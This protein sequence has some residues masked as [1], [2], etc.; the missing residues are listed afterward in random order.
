MQS[1][2]NFCISTNNTSATY[3]KD[4]TP[5]KRLNFNTSKDIKKD[6]DKQ[7]DNINS[8]TLKSLNMA[9]EPNPVKKKMKVNITDRN[10]S[11]IKH[12]LFA[13]TYNSNSPESN[14]PDLHSYFSNEETSSSD[15]L[16]SPMSD[17]N[18]NSAYI[19][20]QENINNSNFNYQS[21]IKINYPANSFNSYG[22]NNLN[23]LS[24]ILFQKNQIV[25]TTTP[26]K[27]TTKTAVPSAP[28]RE[29]EEPLL[30][31]TVPVIAFAY[32]TIDSMPIYS[33]NFEGHQY[34]MKNIGEEIGKERD[35]EKA[36]FHHVYEFLNMQDEDAITINNQELPL[37]GLV[38][39]VAKK[40]V[41]F[42]DRTEYTI[43]QITKRAVQSFD[44]LTEVQKQYPGFSLPTCH[45]KPDYYK[46]CHP[47]TANEVQYGNLWIMQKIPGKIDFSKWMHLAGNESEADMIIDSLDEESKAC[48]KFAKEIYQKMKE[49]DKIVIDDCKPDNVGF[50]TVG[51][52]K[53]KTYQFYILDFSDSNKD[54]PRKYVLDLYLSEWSRG[55]ALV[56]YWLTH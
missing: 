55:N 24:S 27:K 26:V 40:G 50:T 8:L 49:D 31:S 56:K 52:D 7:N 11:P 53:D 41:S 45:V 1:P 47:E 19:K 12:D 16:S 54:E 15:G 48:L 28:I 33:M 30:P 9:N 46:A 10:S 37:S 6:L 4:P 43:A 5:K 20:N 17:D 44:E 13:L 51:T 29:K 14:S 2:I 32:Y 34:L 21:P 38:V 25:D 35:E 39:K 3:P 42:E 22:N 23:L 36:R 18:D